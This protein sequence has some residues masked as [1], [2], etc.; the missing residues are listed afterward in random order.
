MERKFWTISIFIGLLCL[1]VFILSIYSQLELPKPSGSYTVGRRVF[2]WVDPS[3]PELLTEDPNDVREVIAM[4][5]Y[6][7][8]AETGVKA[9]YF[10][11]LSSVSDALMQSGEAEWWQVFGL[12]FVRS[13]SPLEASPRRDQNVFP[14][15][16]LSPGNGTNIEFYSSLAGE[17]AS[18]GYIVVGIN[19]PYDVAAVELSNGT[20]APY[21]KDQWS[22]EPS[23]HQ[24]YSTERMKVRVADLLF[25]LEQLEQL[26]TSGPFAGTMNLDSVA[27][28]GHSLGGIAASETCKADARFKACLNY[29]GL[30]RGGPFSMEETAI[31]PDQPFMF[32]TKES[33]LHPKLIESFES[34]AES[35]WVVLHGASHQSFTDGPL[36]Q[37][38][39][40]P[41]RNRADQFMDL[42]Q[43][44]SIAFLNHTLKGQPAELLSKTVEQEDV[45]VRVFPSN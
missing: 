41:G 16:L 22:L 15:L 25:A 21:D 8:Q 27:V 44:Y 34:T 5:W 42:I 29:D 24:V 23:A 33:Q 26:N 6:P 43:E 7:A 9:A 17:I 2:R 19:H 37:P 3:R 14:V 30:Q 35:Y 10:P 20:V 13:E 11:S 4:V 40:L 31:P 38:S 36:L 39:L 18:H 28:A 1:L 32:I 45:L 12:R